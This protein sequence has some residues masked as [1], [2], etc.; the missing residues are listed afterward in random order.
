MYTEVPIGWIRHTPQR[1]H[2]YTDVELVGYRRAS[3]QRQQQR[4]GQRW[5]TAG[6]F[7]QCT[8]R[9]AATGEYT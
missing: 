4:Q 7:T 3:A 2:G 1:I 9:Q 5:A 8:Q 6:L